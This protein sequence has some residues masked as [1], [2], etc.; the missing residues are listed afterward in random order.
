MNQMTRISR[1]DTSLRQQTTKAL[2]SAILEGI[3]LPGQKLSEREICERLEVSRSCVRESLQHLQA[4]GL[5]TIVPHRGPEVT[6][7][8]VTEVREIYAVRASL[9]SL[10]VQGFITNASAAQRQALRAKV[11]E[12][13]QLALDANHNG[14]LE[15]KNQFYDIL[16]LGCGNALVG[17]LLRQL[18][19]RV[20]V[21]RRLSMA[22]PGRL[23]D[24]LRELDALVGAIEQGNAQE[25]ER[26]CQAHIRNAS[27]NVL[28]NIGRMP[29]R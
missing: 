19:N 28:A 18:N 14:I 3:F 20:T 17:Q 9:E 4:E 1:E 24:T 23:P 29:V 8:T 26:L 13:G 2:R 5:I 27:M 25:A 12:L 7:L 16:M 11:T 10:A 15:V 6:A 21:M 22:Q